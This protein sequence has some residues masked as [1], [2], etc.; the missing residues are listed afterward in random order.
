MNER[1]G[2]LMVTGLGGGMSLVLVLV[3]VLFSGCPGLQ[4]T[5][6][7][8][9]GS[10]TEFDGGGL[11]RMGTT[12]ARERAKIEARAL[13]PGLSNE[14]RLAATR[15]LNALEDGLALAVSVAVRE[16]VNALATAPDGA[17][18]ITIE[19]RASMTAMNTV[20]LANPQG[21][22]PGMVRAA[23]VGGN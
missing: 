19:H 6:T 20:P 14:A 11:V 18:V 23:P 17:L 21:L 3:A 4:K 7:N 13:D 15:E 16:A 12:Y 9:Q 22:R 10:V 8:A 5:T 1:S 2:F